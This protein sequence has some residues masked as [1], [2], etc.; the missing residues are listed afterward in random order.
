MSLFAY[1]WLR[2]TRYVLATKVSNLRNKSHL[3]SKM[4]TCVSNALVICNH[5][6]PSPEGGQEISRVFTF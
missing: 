6:P 4:T 3:Y 1:V 2:H 5:G